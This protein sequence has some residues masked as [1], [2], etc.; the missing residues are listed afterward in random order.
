MNHER[1]FI[2]W[3]SDRPGILTRITSLFF[4]RSINIISLNVAQTHVPSVSKMVIRAAGELHQLDVLR[5][6]IQR[7]VDTLRVDL[8]DPDIVSLD[9]LCFARVGVRSE[10]EREAILAATEP[11]RP[12]ITRVDIDSMIL[13]LTNSPVTIDQFLQALARFTLIDVS[14]TGVTTSP[15][16]AAALTPAQI[17]GTQPVASGRVTH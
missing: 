16:R 9:E 12:R 14:R 2:A 17:H 7:L 8:L 13:Q 10:D 6:Q 11:Y 1:I 5:R 3:V 4:R 15:L